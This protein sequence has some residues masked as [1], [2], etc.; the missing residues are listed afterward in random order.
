MYHTV[1][2]FFC[3]LQCA[4]I[5]CSRMKACG[6]VFLSN[7]HE[8]QVPSPHAVITHNHNYHSIVWW[9][10]TLNNFNQLEP[11]E[12]P[13]YVFFVSCS[14][15]LGNIFSWIDK[16]SLLTQSG[17]GNCPYHGSRSKTKKPDPDNVKTHNG[18]SF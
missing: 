15:Y 3:R 2:L 5:F 4:P 17:L 8:I 7:L 11:F 1:S 6:F 9:L 13:S 14:L 18:R 12:L 10:K 16:I